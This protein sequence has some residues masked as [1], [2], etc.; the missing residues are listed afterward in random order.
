MKHFHERTGML[1]YFK[2][3]WQVCLKFPVRERYAEYFHPVTGRYDEMV[4]VMDRYAETFPVTDR[5]AE[6]FPFKD[7][8]AEIFP[9]KDRYAEIFPVKD[10]YAECSH[11]SES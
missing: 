2:L 3:R 8:Y 5:Y 6:I 1:E 10:R 4:T 9:V 7:R 11:E